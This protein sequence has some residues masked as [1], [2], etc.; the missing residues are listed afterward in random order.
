MAHFAKIVDNRVE[1]II[2]VDNADCAGG[3]FPESEQAG[4]DFI[5]SIGLDGEWVQA[6]Y[7]GSFRGRYPGLNFV[8]DRENDVFVAPE[9]APTHWSEVFE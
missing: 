9:G 7:S 8:Y 1:Q 5:A 3:D 2:V 6:S 4:K